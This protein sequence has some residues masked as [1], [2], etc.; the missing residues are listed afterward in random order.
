MA[1]FED[2]VSS[3]VGDKSGILGD[4]K[5]I[6]NSD[7]ILFVNLQGELK[8]TKDRLRDTESK[9]SE[10]ESMNFNLTRTLEESAIAFENSQH[11]F[12]DK[13][14]VQLM[15]FYEEENKIRENYETQITNLD[16]QLL[17]CQ[18]NNENYPQ[19]YRNQN[20]HG[21]SHQQAQNQNQ[22]K[23]NQAM[24]VQETNEKQAQQLLMMMESSQGQAQAQAQAQ[25]S[26]ANNPSQ[27]WNSP[28]KNGP[29]PPNM[30]MRNNM[31]M[32]HNG[33]HGQNGEFMNDGGYSDNKKN[34]MA[35][36][37]GA[38]FAGSSQGGHNLKGDINN[39]GSKS[40]GYNGFRGG[41][42]SG[43]GGGNAGDPNAMYN[44]SNRDIND[45]KR[46]GKNTRKG[47]GGRGG[48][49]KN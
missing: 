26:P 35:M 31:Q 24:S 19:D 46:G 15:G 12:E 1:A 9:L 41:H 40:G 18:Q 17:N 2:G 14:S 47:R 27:G 49:N 42:G 4:E 48:E 22:N 5:I 45:M 13:L 25:Q 29:L 8:K 21:P 36:N 33:Y 39:Y 7:E 30:Q 6:E 3:S 11:E 43:N 10:L 20:R 28:P 44:T 16:S 23:P 34:M 38:Y 32:Y 37:K